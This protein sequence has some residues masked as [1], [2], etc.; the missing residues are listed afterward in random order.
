MPDSD[1]LFHLGRLSTFFDDP[2][3]CGYLICLDTAL[4]G[5]ALI[6]GLAAEPKVIGE[7]FV[8]R[9]VRRQRLDKRLPLTSSNCTR[10]GGKSRSRRR[11]LALLGSGVG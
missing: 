11:T 2:D 8:V 5:F 1:G 10:G 9:A 3:R 6:R 4:A 7:F